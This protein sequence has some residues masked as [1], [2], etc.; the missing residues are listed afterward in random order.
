MRDEVQDM[1]GAIS[2]VLDM[3]DG[4]SDPAAALLQGGAV[5]TPCP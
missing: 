2:T 5:K 3:S 4:L 1:L